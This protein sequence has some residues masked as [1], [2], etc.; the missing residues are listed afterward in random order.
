MYG[1]LKANARV[2]ILTKIIIGN[3]KTNGDKLKRD[4]MDMKFDIKIH[5]NKQGE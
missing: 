1:M 3:E 2:I 4:V 5:K